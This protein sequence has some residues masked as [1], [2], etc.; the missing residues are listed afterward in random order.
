[1]N[2]DGDDNNIPSDVSHSSLRN[3]PHSH[4]LLSAHH[5]PYVVPTSLHA[6]SVNPQNNHLTFRTHA[7]TEARRC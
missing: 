1:M 6:V 3:I 7:K 5:V 2:N 4:H